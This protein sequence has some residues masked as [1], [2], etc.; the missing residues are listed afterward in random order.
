MDQPQPSPP[1]ELKP[2]YYQYWFL[3]PI[4][5]FWPLWPV[6]ILRSPWHNNLISG[7]VAWAMIFVGGFLIGRQIGWYHLRLGELNDFTV[8]M[9]IPGVFLTVVTQVLWLR[10]RRTVRQAVRTGAPL[11]GPAAPAQTRRS[12][13]RR[14]GPRSGRS[15]RGR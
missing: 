10:D 8:T 14:P 3:Y 15:R 7:A 12:R 13:S 1:N 6:L 4:I 11:A 9:L 2:W 5:V